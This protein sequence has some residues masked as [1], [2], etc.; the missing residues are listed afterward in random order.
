MTGRLVLLWEL[1]L[2]N[3]MEKSP[4]QKQQ[5]PIQIFIQL[6]HP[7]QHLDSIVIMSLQPRKMDFAK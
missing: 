5:N 7:N 3:K 1:V 2:M 6:H 4:P